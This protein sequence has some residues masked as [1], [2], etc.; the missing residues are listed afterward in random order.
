MTN[1]NNFQIRQVTTDDK[2]TLE[3][4]FKLR[5][6]CRQEQGFITFDKYPNGW[7]DDTDFSSTHFAAFH[8]NEPIAAGRISYYKNIKIHP[9]YSAIK[10]IQIIEDIKEF[11]YLSR[12]CVHPEY[13]T[14][15]LSNELVNI[16]EQ[17][18]LKNQIQKLLTDVSGFQFDN[19]VKYGYEEIGV[20]N[21]SEIKWDVDKSIKYYLMRKIL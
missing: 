18:S 8:E 6:T 7:Y 10:H 21:L 16:R 4:I 14:N 9:Y 3:K 2:V 15:K 11:G 17:H 13:R 20:L 12:V 1:N 5:V 19:Y